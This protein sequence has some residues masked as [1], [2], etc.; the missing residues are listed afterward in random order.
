MFRDLTYGK[1]RH[2][3]A[4]IRRPAGG[5]PLW[6]ALVTSFRILAEALRGG[7]SAFRRYEHLRSRGVQHDAAIR[8]ALDVPYSRAG[9]GRSEQRGR[10]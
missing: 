5:Q 7:L 9:S 1:I 3:Q 6:P 2:A 4:A 8:G 10:R